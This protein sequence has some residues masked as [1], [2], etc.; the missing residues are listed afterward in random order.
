M[1]F[2]LGQKGS[3][4]AVRPRRATRAMV[5]VLQL[6]TRYVV[7]LYPTRGPLSYLQEVHVSVMG[8]HLSRRSPSSLIRGPTSADRCQQDCKRA[9]SRSL[10][11]HVFDNTSPNRAYIYAYAHTSRRQSVAI[12][13]LNPF[14]YAV[15][16]ALEVSSRYSL[17]VFAVCTNKCSVPPCPYVL[18]CVFLAP[19]AC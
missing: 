7:T 1:P 14:C 12:A 3:L 15:S 17:S 19:P 16:G 6:C 8:S 10:C 2:H 11:Y 9:V 13:R 18:H 4:L 5:F